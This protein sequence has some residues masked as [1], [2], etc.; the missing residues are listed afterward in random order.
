MCGGPH[1]DVPELRILMDAVQASSFITPSKT[2]VLLDKIAD[3]GGSHRAELL[4]SNIV[5]YVIK[6]C[7]ILDCNVSDVMTVDKISE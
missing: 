3:L 6:I 4:R 7:E 5:I 2:E 1:F